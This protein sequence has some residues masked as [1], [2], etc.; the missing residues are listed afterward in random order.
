MKKKVTY[1]ESDRFIMDRIIYAYMF[2]V[3]K[4]MIANCHFMQRTNILRYLGFTV[5]YTVE[6]DGCMKYLI[7]LAGIGLV[8]RGVDAMENG[9][10]EVQYNTRHGI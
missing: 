1:Y 9:N 6:P 3:G 5:E 8:F 2:L 10:V 4:S 7:E